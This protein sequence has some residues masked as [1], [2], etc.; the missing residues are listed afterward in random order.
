M[1]LNT[2]NNQVSQQTPPDVYSGFLNLK[3]GGSA[4]KSVFGLSTRLFSEI[5]QVV[6]LIIQTR[7]QKGRLERKIHPV[8]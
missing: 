6:L 3:C 8:H 2:N 4:F 1:Q 5:S 7:Q